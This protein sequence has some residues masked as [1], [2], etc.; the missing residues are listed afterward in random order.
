MLFPKSDWD[1]FNVEGF[2]PNAKGNDS[3]SL[4]KDRIWSQRGIRW[5]LL[6]FISGLVIWK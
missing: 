5:K 3:S 4:N 6:E 2:G 1:G